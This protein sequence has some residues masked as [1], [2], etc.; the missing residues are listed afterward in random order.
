MAKQT[1]LLS[2]L[3]VITSFAGCSSAPKMEEH[4][5]T[6]PSSSQLNPAKK[7]WTH[8]V[9]GLL[10][11]LNLSADGST[12][13]IATVPDHDS[14][15]SDANRSMYYAVFYSVSGKMLSEIQMP[16]QIKSQTLAG[17]GSFGV[18]ASYDDTLRA[19]DRKGQELW[20]AEGFCKPTILN[21]QKKILCFHDD[22]AQPELGFELFGF[23]GK[24]DGE[25]PIKD[26]ALVMKVSYDEHFAIMALN[27]GKLIVFNKHFKP[28][29]HKTV[30]GEI[31]DVAVGNA[32]G[33]PIYA[34]LFNRKKSDRQVI[35]VFGAKNTDLEVKDHLSQIEL[36]PTGDVVYGYSNADGQLLVG[37][38]PQSKKSWK[39]EEKRSAEFSSQISVDHR[40]AWMGF[41]DVGESGA[42]SHVLGFDH[43]GGLKTN[44]EVPAGEGA[45]LYT[46]SV[47]PAMGFVAVGSDDG[48]LTLFS[49][50]K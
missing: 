35:R 3:F 27:H 22:D 40:A 26:D 36:S 45:F 38:D 7:L 21:R 29:T 37:W 5:I 39:R 28:E 17:D 30:P 4:P 43:L 6:F 19:Y 18:I 44:I 24:K 48:N 14:I 47:A 46:Y 25:F 12:V 49:V 2:A 33:K 13:L 16:A 8:K 34:A 32:S 1:L 41:E 23:D 15:E 42:H 20:N 31:V 10:T 9:P 11:D 50:G